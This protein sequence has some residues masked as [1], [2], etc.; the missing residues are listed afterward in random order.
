MSFPTYH[1]FDHDGKHYR[2]VI[3]ELYQTRGSYGYD[4]E[5]ETKAAEDEEIEKLNDGTWVALGVHV[6]RKCG[7]LEPP[8]E[9]GGE[10]PHCPGCGG[11][12][13]L[14][15]LWGIVIENSAAACEKFVKDGF[16]L[17]YER[18]AD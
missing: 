15:D 17:E 4:T 2:F 10:Q 14:D 7:G 11:V 6:T 16:V 3:D 8:I 9:P 13:E 12:E 18:S 1:Q 5:E